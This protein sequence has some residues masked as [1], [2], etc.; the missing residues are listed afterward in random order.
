MGIAAVGAGGGSLVFSPFC[1]WLV[2]SYGWRIAYV[3]LGVVC[4]GLFIPIVKLIK[5]APGERNKVAIEGGNSLSFAFSEALRTGA[6]WMLAFVWFFVA[7]ALF[8]IMIHI[9]PLL[10]DR[11]VPFVTAGVLAGLM[12][13][14]SIIGRISG[15]F[16]SD[17]KGR[18]C[19]LLVALVFQLITLIWFLFSNKFWMFFLFA[20]FF[21]L[22][23][24]GWGGI[25]GAFPADFFGSKATGTILG[26]ILIFA[27]TGA[28]I[29]PYVGGYIFDNTGSYY[30]M[31][32]VCIFATVI[33]IV[34]GLLLKSPS[35]SMGMKRKA[36]LLL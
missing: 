30:H 29:G 3:V 31:I 34:F 35:K 20:A 10:T 4:W 9:I 7:L 26:F 36:S 8:A 33:A 15:G 2:S 21:G 17:K 12:G 14:V 25:I 5:R 22:S 19:I 23:F 18:K 32:W 11:G 16:L 24:G 28:A 27:G 13:G 1:A 6:F